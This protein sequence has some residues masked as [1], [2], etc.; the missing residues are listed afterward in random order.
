MG[1]EVTGNRG[2][3]ECGDVDGVEVEVVV[4]TEKLSWMVR[5]FESKKMS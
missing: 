5:I 3:G 4:V 2:V 1:C